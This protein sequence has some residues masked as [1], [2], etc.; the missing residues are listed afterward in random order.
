MDWWWQA[1]IILGMFLLR[2][3]VPLAITLLVGYWL[4][5]LDAKWQAQWEASRIEPEPLQSKFLERLNQPCWAVNGCDAATRVKC[6][7]FRQPDLPCW[8]V[9]R[10]PDGRLP[11][12]CYGC[13]I[14]LYGQLGRP[15]LAGHPF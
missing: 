5:R 4:H 9:W 10:G 6:P 11:E 14:F 2:L 1:A 12:P 8:Q 15:L 7:A 3:A 13:P